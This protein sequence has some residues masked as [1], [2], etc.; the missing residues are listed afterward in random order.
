MTVE[1]WI[2]LTVVILCVAA[3]CILS[4]GFC[5]AENAKK[6]AEAHETM[7]T[8]RTESAVA[9]IDTIAQN[10]EAAAQQHAEVKEAQDEIR[11]LPAG[12]DRERLARKRLCELQGNSAC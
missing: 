4:L 8:G 6:T 11:S 1:R 5:H 2:T 3:V 10:T 9:A 7:A 12:P